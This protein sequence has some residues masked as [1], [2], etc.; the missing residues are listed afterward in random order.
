MRFAPRVAILSAVLLIV[1]FA[2]NP[3]SAECERLYPSGLNQT[4]RAAQSPTITQVNLE[5]V[6]LTNDACRL[7]MVVQGDFSSWHQ[8]IENGRVTKGSGGTR[9]PG[10]FGVP[11][12]LHF[13]ELSPSTLRATFWRDNP[14]SYDDLNREG[15]PRSSSFL[16]EVDSF[17][18]SVEEA[19]TGYSWRFP[20][21]P[22]YESA[23]LPALYQKCMQDI[24]LSREGKERRIYIDKHEIAISMARQSALAEIAFLDGE[25]IMMTQALSDIQALITQASEAISNALEKRRK[26]I[27]LE[28]QYAETINAFWA[29]QTQA[30]MTFSTWATE[31]LSNIDQQ[32]AEAEQ[33]RTTI[34]QLETEFQQ[35][36]ADTRERIRQ[37]VE[38]LEALATPETE[39][40]GEEN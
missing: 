21:S 19:D 31:R 15:M 8:A 20:I 33:F 6:T 7:D 38:E 30:Y 14:K 10:R 4:C 32:L 36:L 2:S 11:F 12:T 27:T 22:P 18:W 1:L 24:E 26:L 5:V 37:K 28:E 16:S 40:N 34:E 25:I 39:T 23:N 13:M 9:T 35:E 3:V 17:G 29:E